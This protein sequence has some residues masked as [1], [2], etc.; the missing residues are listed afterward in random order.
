MAL[1]LDDFKDRMETMLK[2]GGFFIQG[3]YEEDDT[4]YGPS[5]PGSS[6]DVQ[7]EDIKET[8]R[9]LSEI[10][11][12]HILINLQDPAGNP[13]LIPNIFRGKTSTMGSIMNNMAIKIEEAIQQL[14]TLQS[15]RTTTKK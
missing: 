3:Y 14:K 15:R 10:I 4:T 6:S 13:Y 8:A 1:E 7:P 5:W 11:A 2:G 12:K 9:H